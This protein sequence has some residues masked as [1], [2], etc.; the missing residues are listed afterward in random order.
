MILIQYLVTYLGWRFVRSLQ[1][2]QDSKSIR[3]IQP[4][5]SL[6]AGHGHLFDI[7]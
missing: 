3:A 4:V 7:L 2:I 1:K 6:L 5:A